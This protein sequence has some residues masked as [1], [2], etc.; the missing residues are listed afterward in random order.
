MTGADT[1]HIVA[2]GSPGS[3]KTVY[4]S[5]LHHVLGADSEALGRWITATVAEPE[6]RSLLTRTYNQAVEPTDEWPI[7][8]H[9]GERMREFEFALRVSW[10][11]Q[12]V[13]GKLKRHTFRPMNVS[14]VDYAG[15]WIP[16]GDQQSAEVLDPFKQR[17]RE[18]HALLGIIDGLKLLQFML[19]HPLGASF[20]ED[21]VRPIVAFMEGT[22]IPLHF[23]I[24][25]WDLL[26]SRDFTLASV[27]NKLLGS[28]AA[29]F[30]KL[31]ESRTGHGRLIRRPQGTIRLV[32]VTAVGGLAVLRDDW[33]ITKNA[34]GR[35]TQRNVETP[36]AAAVH[37]IC[38]LAVRRLRGTR[39]DDEE[40]GA[41]AGAVGA[42][43]ERAGLLAQ[44]QLDGPHGFDARIG[45][46][47]ITVSLHQIA[48]F[49]ADSGQEVV[50]V[51]GKPAVKTGRAVRR[52][53][54]RV[55]A[56][57]VHGVTSPEAALYYVMRTLRR[58]LQD[59]EQEQPGSMLDA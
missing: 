44:R 58:K 32:P 18:A 49:V 42:D 10:T 24:T 41:A 53:V 38:D 59:F 11:Q 31:V 4:L 9:S 3:G 8:T 43:V 40:I 23:I 30:R 34:A 16:D 20:M 39:E 37:D 21:Q 15:E 56:R 1:Y 57:D 54:R 19:D 46:S 50:K 13:F 12:S 27:R 17:V 48:A 29:G 2:L 35:A 52:G 36:L 28:D 55:K 25:K 26:E 47:G 7:G 14:Y 6:K 45:P 51:L 5:A 22:D 33:T